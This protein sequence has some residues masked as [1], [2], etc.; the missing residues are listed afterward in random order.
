MLV[1]AASVFAAPGA[2]PARAAVP[3]NAVNT[4][5]NS[6]V[7]IEVER[8]YYGERFTTTGTGFFVTEDGHILTNSHVVSDWIDV[9]VR[10][11]LRDTFGVP[12]YLGNDADVAALAEYRFG[13]GRGVDDMVYMTISTGIG[14]GFIFGGRL[15]TG[16]NGLGGEPGLDDWTGTL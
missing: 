1:L 16:G 14:G 3:V 8:T 7:F 12:A 13:A 15:F 2:S 11:M 6:T 10:Q 5:L 9:P 4:A